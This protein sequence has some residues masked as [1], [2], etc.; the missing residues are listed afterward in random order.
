MSAYTPAEAAAALAQLKAL[1]QSDVPWYEQSAISDDLLDKIV[2]VVLTAAAQVR[3]QSPT[4][5]T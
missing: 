1:E 3:G 4:Q 2:A 5:G